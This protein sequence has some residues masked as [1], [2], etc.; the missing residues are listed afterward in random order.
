MRRYKM[1]LEARIVSILRAKNYEYRFSYLHVIDAYITD[2]L[3]RM[4]KSGNETKTAKV[5]S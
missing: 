3:D 1:L 5:S 2:I 4:S